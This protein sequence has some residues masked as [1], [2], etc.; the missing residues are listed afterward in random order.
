MNLDE[1]IGFFCTPPAQIAEL[2]TFSSLFMLRREAQDCLIGKVIDEDAV[3]EEAMPGGTS[4]VRDI[5]GRGGG[6][7]PA[8]EVLR[9]VR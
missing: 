1:K 6:C 7:G 5:D 2:G 4:A 9:R 3:I 8:G